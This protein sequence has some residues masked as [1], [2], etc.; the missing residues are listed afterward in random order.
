MNLQQLKSEIE[1]DPTAQ[2][3]APHVASGADSLVAEMLN[4]KTRQV[5]R[6]IPIF[7]FAMWCSISGIRA[8]LK[9]GMESENATIAAI[10]DTA[11]AVQSNP[12]ATYLDLTD[13]GSAG[14]MTALVQA[15]VITQSESQAL[16]AFCTR[17]TSR[18]E[19]LFGFGSR[20]D[21]SMVAK[22]LR[23]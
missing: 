23:G 3:Y 4:A 19:E 10:C 20:V 18:A 15:G 8:K 12:H 14:M 1:N 9:A 7:E 13:A 5:L 16:I 11:L 6:P 17:P 2:G 22:A 21:D